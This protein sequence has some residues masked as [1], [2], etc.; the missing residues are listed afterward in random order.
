MITMTDD[1]HKKIDL[2]DSIFSALTV[3]QLKEIAESEQVVAKL[4]GT[5]L[6]PGLLRKLI[7]DQEHYSVEL[8]KL[9]SEIQALKYNL[10]TLTKLMLKP[11]DYSSQ[12]DAQNLKSNMGIY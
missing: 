2:L 5:S 8:M 1:Q 6:D 9:D 3:E 12:L 4:K 10:Q 11:Y 7:Q